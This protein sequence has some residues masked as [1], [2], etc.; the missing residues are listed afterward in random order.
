MSLL[1]SKH[2]GLVRA[3]LVAHYD[4]SKTNLLYMCA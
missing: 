1:L 4:F 2:E 3:G